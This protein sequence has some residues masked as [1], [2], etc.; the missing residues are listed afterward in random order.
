MPFYLFTATL[1][2]AATLLAVWTA[3]AWPHPRADLTAGMLGAA[4]VAIW[5]VFNDTHAGPAIGS[6][7][8]TVADIASLPALLV[9][10]LLVG[11]TVL[12]RNHPYQPMTETG[13][14][15]NPRDTAREPSDEPDT[16]EGHS[17]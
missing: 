15:A 16:P 14:A 12:L 17:D 5:S 4:S 11:R 13:P 3:M 8:L 2:A 1:M 9:S 10:S 7:P 6:L